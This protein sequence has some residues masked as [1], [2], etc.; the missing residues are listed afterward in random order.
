METVF[1]LDI[2]TRVVIGLVVQKSVS[3]YEVVASARTEH[4]QRAMYDGQVHDVNE[5]AKAVSFVKHELEHKLNC[6]LTKVAVAAAGRAL[7]TETATVTREEVLP[8]HWEQE[9]V[10][11]MEMEA[12]QKA[13]KKISAEETDNILFYCVGYSTVKQLLEDQQITTLVGQRGKKAEITVISS[14][15]PRTVVDG[16][17]AVLARAG[18][19]MASL[20]LEPI[21][22]GLAAIPGDMRRLNLALVDIGAG[23]ADIAFTKEGTFFAYGMVPM[24]GDEVTE[25]ICS[26]YLVD[27]QEGERIKKQLNGNDPNPNSLIDIVNFFG[28][29]SSVTRQEILDV[30]KPTVQVIAERIGGEILLLNNSCSPQAVIMVGGGSLTPL[31]GDILSKVI[32]LSRGRIGIQV[33]ERLSAVSG[34]EED[35]F[36]SDVITPIGI[37]ISALD[38]KGLHYYAVNVNNTNIP[39]F[40]L[41]LATVAEGL[42]AA[43]IQPKT[44]FGRPGSALIYKLNGEIQVIKGELG[45]PAVITVNGQ[46]AKLDQRLSQGDMVTFRPGHSGE[47]AKAQVK[48]VI[49]RPTAKKII[50]DGKEEEFNPFIYLNNKP[51]NE[52]DW[53]EDG[54]SLLVKMNETLYDLLAMK[55]I[56]INKINKKKIKV[57]NQPREL[58]SDLEIIVNG[59]AV[60]IDCVINN[61]D[62]ID[63]LEKK[64]LIRDL[65]LEAEPMIFTVNGEAFSLPPFEAKIYCKGRVIQEDEPIEDGMEIRVEGFSRKPI[66]S[67]LFPYINLAENSISGGKLEMQVNGSEAHFTTELNQG[68]RIIVNWINKFAL[69]K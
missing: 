9:E 17:I 46:S 65:A 3:G 21:A 28:A 68:D 42:L 59:H 34:Q 50:W 44:F 57:N 19:E 54:C 35:L 33:R 64:I 12:V 31:M 14:F 10:L 45:S 18:L 58:V 2:G 41:Q 29:R 63:I 61:N 15:L 56:N 1:A 49:S 40:E 5:V 51:A 38:N 30:I 53:L 67:E 16:L 7:C 32:N 39:L 69:A 24:A 52:E 4:T 25:A 62:R 60:T 48:D 26:N 37:A 6:K 23:T 11:A 47:D 27:F 8:T 20:T 55:G 22:A 43:G 13:M 36:G 66:L